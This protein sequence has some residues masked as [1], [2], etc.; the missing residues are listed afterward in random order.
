MKGW[1][2]VKQVKHGTVHR[3]PVGPNV[4]SLGDAR[5]AG[6]EDMRMKEPI[7]VYADTSVFGGAQD[8]EFSQLSEPFFARVRAGAIQ[9]VV[10]AVV[11][12]LRARRKP[13]AILSRNWR[14]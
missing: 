3:V 9:I 12:S 2:L 7:R 10:S 4:D 6:F 13:S 14:R 8:R 1:D 11:M 5:A